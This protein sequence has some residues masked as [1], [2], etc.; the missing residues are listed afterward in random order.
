M[1]REQELALGVQRNLTVYEK[2]NI[3]VD[4]TTGEVLSQSTDKLTKTSGEPDF[5]K[6]YYK[7]M[8]AF[9]GADDIPLQFV[10]AL[11]G[12]INW[13]ND[14]EPMLFHNN[15]IVKENICKV[16]KIKD[17]MYARYLSRC[18]ENGLLV[19]KNGYRGVYEVNPFFIA[20]G[21]WEN[22]KQMRATFDFVGGKW[23]RVEEQEPEQYE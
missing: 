21:K 2:T 3:V 14:G 17:T 7:T 15:K 23:E 4:V 20:K 5:V 9:N 6:V 22:I 1:T 12:H 18:R 19:P 16:C 8:L 11:S 13:A 10:M